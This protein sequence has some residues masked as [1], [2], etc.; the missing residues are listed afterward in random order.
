MREAVGIG[1]P[2]FSAPWPGNV[3]RRPGPGHGQRHYHRCRRGIGQRLRVL[4]LLE[5]VWRSG[6]FGHGF[7]R[8]F[9]ATWVRVPV[10]V[11]ETFSQ[12]LSSTSAQKRGRSRTRT[13]P[14]DPTELAQRRQNQDCC[15][16]HE[17]SHLL[18]KAWRRMGRG[19]RASRWPAT[20][21]RP[22]RRLLSLVSW[23][24]RT[25][26]TRPPGGPPADHG[27]QAAAGLKLKASYRTRAFQQLLVSRWIRKRA[28]APVRAAAL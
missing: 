26:Q 16:N 11:R 6:A 5:L 27:I 14:G 10:T 3:L 15:T 18:A 20:K 12:T 19:L 7:F 4:D 25:R 2:G 17:F 28:A 24:D 1:L 8:I 13:L 9:E 21:H 23:A 22:I